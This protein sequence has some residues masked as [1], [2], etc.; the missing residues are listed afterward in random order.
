MRATA[1]L[2]VLSCLTLLTSSASAAPHSLASLWLTASCELGQLS[3][4]VVSGDD[5]T[6]PTD[7]FAARQAALR[8]VSDARPVRQPAGSPVRQPTVKG[9]QPVTNAQEQ[10][11]AL[12][13]GARRALAAGQQQQALQLIAQ[14]KKL[15]ITYPLHADSP[16][17]IEALAR[18]ISQ[19]A[20]EATAPAD[21]IAYQRNQSR[22]L[23]D[24]A[25]GLI[26]YAAY[27]EAKQLSLIHI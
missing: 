16:L 4:P 26:R 25:R 7:P 14:A 21:P 6:L 11:H 10:S 18:R 23:M 9:P 1:P 15:G 24:Q 17:K 13:L 22:L 27:A 12:L 2:F 8:T 5:T 20:A 3:L 19:S